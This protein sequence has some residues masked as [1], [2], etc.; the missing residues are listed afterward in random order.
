MNVSQIPLQGSA[1]SNN[2][3]KEYKELF[4]SL[5]I[6]RKD[7]FAKNRDSNFTKEL[8]K[9]IMRSFVFRIHNI[10]DNNNLIIIPCG[11]VAKYF[12][13]EYLF[14]K[15]KNSIDDISHPSNWTGNIENIRS[16]I[17]D[18]SNINFY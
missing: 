5:N 8:E 4:K 13:K 16:K 2:L 3:R 10:L 17:F 18:W 11:H 14:L 7:P 1:Y 6:I 15:D 9:E 12:Y